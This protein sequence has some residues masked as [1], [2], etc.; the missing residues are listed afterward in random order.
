MSIVVGN[1]QQPAQLAKP[2]EYLSA[3]LLHTAENKPP[4]YKLQRNAAVCRLEQCL[5]GSLAHF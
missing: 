1:M 4:P 2:Q 5:L 3:G